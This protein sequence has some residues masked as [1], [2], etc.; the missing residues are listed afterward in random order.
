MLAQKLL[1]AA[2]TGTQEAITTFVYF[3]K[4]FKGLD[5]ATVEEYT[6]LKEN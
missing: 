1:L 4:K 5:G 6:S 3:P 2:L